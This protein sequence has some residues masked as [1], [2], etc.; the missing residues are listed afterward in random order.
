MLQLMIPNCSLLYKINEPLCTFLN[1]EYAK[2]PML[3]QRSKQ[4]KNKTK[5][6]SL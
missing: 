4:N 5:V 1:K 6:V 3:P 2:Q